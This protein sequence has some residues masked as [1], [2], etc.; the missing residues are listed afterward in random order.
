MWAVGLEDMVDAARLAEEKLEIARASHGPYIKDGKPNQKHVPKN[1]KTSS[2][3]IVTL[4]ERIPS[5]LNQASNP[6]NG[7]TGMGGRQYVRGRDGGS[8]SG[9]RV[10]SELRCGFDSTEYVQDKRNGGGLRNSDHGG[11]W[12]YP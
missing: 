1:S 3:K 12:G 7:A 9:G 8:Q 2:T 6:Q 11:L 10:I 5:S 4:A